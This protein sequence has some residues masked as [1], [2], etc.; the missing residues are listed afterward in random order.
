M[1]VNIWKLYTWTAHKDVNMKA[2]F[3]IM[4][5][6]W[7]VVKIRPKKKFRPV[8]ELNAWP[9]W[10]RCSALPALHLL[11]TYYFCHHYYYH[12]REHYLYYYLL[13]RAIIYNSFCLSVFNMLLLLLLSFLWL[14][15]WLLVLLPSKE[16]LT[17]CVRLSS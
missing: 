1:T 9:L 6:A 11:I 4:K 7:A 17:P 14:L 12:D 10:Y 13:P 5:T 8:W 16:L 2:I 15:L 3:A